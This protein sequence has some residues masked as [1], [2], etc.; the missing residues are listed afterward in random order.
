M[1]SLVHGRVE[2]LSERLRRITAPNPGPMTG[3][4]TNTYIV[5]GDAVAVVDPGPMETAH[6]DAILEAVGDRIQ[7]VLVTHTHPDHSPA[8][9][10]LLEATGAQAIGML[11]E[12]RLFQDQTFSP[13]WA[14]QNGDRLATEEFSLR[15]I[16]TPGHVSNHLCF[17]LEEEGVLL[18]GDHIMQGSTVVIVPPGGD[19]KDYIESLQHLTDYPL[20]SIAPAHGEL[21]DHPLETIEWLI[22]HRLMREDK[23]LSKLTATPKTL[24]EL[25][26][27][28]YDD[29][30]VSLHDMAKLSLHAHLLKLQ[31][32]QRV[33]CDDGAGTWWL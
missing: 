30:D 20:K 18:A 2:R 14:I 3:A 13:D 32:E 26:S 4:G 17:L 7:W 24:D 16:H 19:M 23:L 22:A 15:A 1:P 12:D 27:R 5:G 6:I 9:A 21:M 25:L 11:A 29:V 28:V 31:K 10:P 33:R 8:A